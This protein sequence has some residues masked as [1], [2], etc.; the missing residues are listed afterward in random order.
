MS[1][2]WEMLREGFAVEILWIV[3]GIVIGNILNM[4]TR[5]IVRTYRRNRRRREVNLNKEVFLETKNILSLDHADP[6]Y[7][8]HDIP[9]RQTMKRLYIGFPAELSA[10]VLSL[11]CDFRI[12][13]NISFSGEQEFSDLEEITGII[14]LTQMIQ[15][16]KMQV[17]E[18]FI[19]LIK[20]GRTLFNGEKYGIYRIKPGRTSDEFENA[21]FRLDLFCTDYFTHRVFRSIYKEL[22]SNNHPIGQVRKFEELHSYYPFLTSFGMNTFVIL[23]DEINMEIVFAKRSKYIGINA[24][25]SIWHVTMNEGLTDTDKDGKDVSLIKCL[26]RGL[27]EE[28]GIRAEHHRFIEEE[29]FMDL[30]LEKGN[31]EIGITSF[32]KLNMNFNELKK[33]YAG[34]KDAELETDALEV[35]T[36]STKEINRFLEQNKLS[37]AAAYNLSMLLA[38]KKYLGE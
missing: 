26:H 13:S 35:V 10:E 7:E 29:F 22:V 28:L 17:G 4:V 6:Y 2:F 25:E 30:F 12:R 15:Q 31:F 33:L 8:L 5:L 36:L 20:E 24:T 32:V 9:V 16:H 11:D 38:R 3:L 19:R 23:D 37:P 27:R 1:K 21:K 18:E 14:G 34:A